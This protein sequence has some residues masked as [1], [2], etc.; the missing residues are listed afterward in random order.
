M[1]PVTLRR[2]PPQAGSG[3]PSETGWTPV[4]PGTVT[5]DLARMREIRLEI[6]PGSGTVL[7]EVEATHGP[8]RASIWTINAICEKE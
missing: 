4:V 7:A 2:T 8:G 6:D 3:T 1:S 5:I